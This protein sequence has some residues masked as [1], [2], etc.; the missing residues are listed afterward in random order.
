IETVPGN[1]PLRNDPRL[2]TIFRNN[3]GKLFGEESYCEYLHGGGSTDAGDLSQLM[4]VLHPMMT[5]ARGKVHSTEW[6]IADPD[7]GY[8]APAKSLAMMVIDLLSDG[9]VRAREVL[10]Q[11]TPTM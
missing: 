11:H 4:P 1:L 3:A 10:A 6:H 9:A 8:L 2:A 7:A 5:G